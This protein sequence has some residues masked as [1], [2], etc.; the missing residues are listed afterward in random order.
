MKKT[1]KF[2]IFGALALISIM[3]ITVFFAP[4]NNQLNSGSTYSRAPD[5][6]GA[7]YNFMLEKGADIQRW[8][9]PFI[10]LEN[11][12]DI[13]SSVTLLQ[14]NSQLENRVINARIKN[15]VK[16]GNILVILGIKKQVTKAEFTTIHDTEVGKV[17]IETSRRT[18]KIEQKEEENLLGD[19]YGA[20]VWQKQFGKGRIIL[21]TT[22]YLAANAYQDIPGNYEFLAQLVTQGQQRIL[23][24][25]YIHG[26]KDQE[27]IKEELGESLV[28]YLIETPLFPIFIQGLIILVILIF[29]QNR[30]FAKPI[31]LSAPIVDNSQA[32]IQA[33][34]GV[35]QK[36][37]SRE[38]ILETTG[39]EQK[40]KLQKKLGLGQNIVE[41]KSLIDA[42]IQQT[43]ES[44]IELEKVLKI[45]SQKRKITESE[46]LNWLDKW[47]KIF[48][49]ENKAKR[50]V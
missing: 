44:S 45:Q 23:V 24:D 14:V 50:D 19:R 30:R 12:Q 3:I 47:E 38:F 35:L 5:G 36:A 42:W 43:G 18:I 20:I 40:I 25:E 27:V 32:Y 26:Y 2:W 17:E 9:K 48:Q 8:E 15:W 22:Q 37:E 1:K 39:K 11:T 13:N 34:A 46:L 7:W 28:N 41:D 49:V 33:L 6:Y 29:A 21:A 31:K 4:V 10:D 16:S